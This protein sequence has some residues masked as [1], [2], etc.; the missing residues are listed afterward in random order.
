MTIYNI[1]GT[2]CDYGQNTL[3]PLH[4]VST[5]I[6]RHNTSNKDNLNG[7]IIWILGNIIIF[8]YM[9]CDS[10]KY[11]NNFFSLR[12]CVRVRNTFNGDR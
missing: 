11:L 10:L 2:L 3:L 4:F 1:H 6:R 7:E 8:A 5:R 12:F 9:P